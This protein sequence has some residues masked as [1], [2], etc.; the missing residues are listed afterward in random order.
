MIAYNFCFFLTDSYED[1]YKQVSEIEEL[2]STA[3]EGDDIPLG[4]AIRRPNTLKDSRRKRKANQRNEHES[5]DGKLK[6][7]L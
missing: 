5:S 4:D 1:A 3:G 2:C 7:M 6:E